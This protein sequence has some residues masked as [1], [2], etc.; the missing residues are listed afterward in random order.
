MIN[1]QDLCRV[2]D[3][4]RATGEDCLCDGCRAAIILARAGVQLAFRPAPAS[5]DTD[6]IARPESR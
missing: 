4:A 1:E 5:G 6:R 2:C 3:T